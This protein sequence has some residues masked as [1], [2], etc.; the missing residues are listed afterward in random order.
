MTTTAAR[1][2]D[3]E[4]HRYRWRRTRCLLWGRIVVGLLIKSTFFSSET[5]VRKYTGVTEEDIIINVEHDVGRSY[6][7]VGESMAVKR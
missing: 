3:R 5:W 2:R 4:E 6:V 7:S 1:A